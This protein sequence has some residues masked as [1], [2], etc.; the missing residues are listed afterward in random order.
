MPSAGVDDDFFALGGHSLLAMRLVARARGAAASSW[1]S[2]TSSTHPTPAGLAAVLAARAGAAAG[3]AASGAAGASPLSSAQHRLW[4]LDRL[5]RARRQLQHPVVLRLSGRAGRRALADGARTT[6]PA[7]TRALRTVFPDDG[8]RAAPAGPADPGRSAW[9]RSGSVDRGRLPARL[10]EAAGQRL[11]PGARDCPC[12]RRCSPAAAER[13]RA[14]AGAAP[15]RGRRLVAGAA[16]RATWRRPTRPGWPA[17]RPRW[18]PLPVQYAD[19]TL[20]QRDL[21]GDADDPDSLAARARLATGRE[22]LDR[23]AGRAR[24]AA[25]PA[26]PGRRRATGGG[27]CVDFAV[28]AGAARAR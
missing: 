3:C 20:W 26:A 7:G 4:F 9:R 19:Y 21:L 15:H 14:A 16:D 2:A 17:R 13:A 22:A 5:G 18:P 28:P 27:G 10:A 1:P 6:W 23:P 12:A 24:P 8:R 11:R 25:G